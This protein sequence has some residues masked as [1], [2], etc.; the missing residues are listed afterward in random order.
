MNDSR[1]ACTRAKSPITDSRRALRHSPRNS[2][3]MGGTYHQAP[4]KCAYVQQPN[5]A[6]RCSKTN[7]GEHDHLRC[8]VNDTTG[9]CRLAQS[10]ERA[11][12]AAKTSVAPLVDAAHALPESIST[13]ST[14][15][16][17]RIAFQNA[18]EEL[19]ASHI[20]T[21]HGR[22][23]PRQMWENLGHFEYNPHY[24]SRYSGLPIRDPYLQASDIVNGYFNHREPLSDGAFK[25]GAH[26]SSPVGTQSQSVCVRQSS[27]KYTSPTRKSPPYPAN[28]C[29]GKIMAGN[30]GNWYQSTPNVNS[31]YTWKRRD[32]REDAFPP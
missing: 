6:R 21:H 5:G 13:P 11:K 17:D 26:S 27:A 9:R 15:S 8:E 16:S 1:Y 24:V 4:V 22:W 31:I 18:F 19:A 29:R 2:S 14:P 23:V 28:Q 10:K 20:Q 32:F 30:D 7:D 12:D 3:M 25:H